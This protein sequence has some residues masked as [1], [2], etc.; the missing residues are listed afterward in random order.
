MLPYADFAKINQH[1][2]LEEIENKNHVRSK[3]TL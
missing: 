2:R 1:Y 3:T